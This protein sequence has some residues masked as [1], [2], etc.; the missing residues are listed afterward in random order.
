MRSVNRSPQLNDESKSIEQIAKNVLQGSQS[1]PSWYGCIRSPDFDF[2]YMWFRT[3]IDQIGTCEKCTTHAA[4]WADRLD[5]YIKTFQKQLTDDN[6][7][8]RPTTV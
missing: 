7:A 8:N 4:Q 1:W 2:R 5:S 3:I 6:T